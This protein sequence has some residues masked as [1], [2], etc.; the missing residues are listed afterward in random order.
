MAHYGFQYMK[1]R[2]AA[3]GFRNDEA[4]QSLGISISDAHPGCGTKH[5]VQMRVWNGDGSSVPE[6]VL[7][8]YRSLWAET[9]LI[10]RSANPES[11][12]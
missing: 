7:A 3:D 2:A 9:Y 5:A 10:Y 12:Q 11:A 8:Y 6:D 1:A 4:R